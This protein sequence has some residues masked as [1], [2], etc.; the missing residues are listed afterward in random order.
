[1]RVPAHAIR[2]TV[3][4]LL[5]NDGTMKYPEILLLPV[6][7]FL[8]YF[9]T[10]ASAV[11]C[12]KGHARHFKVIHLELNPLWQKSVASKKWFN[13]K[14]ILLTVIFSSAMIF[15]VEFA[16]APPP[17]LEAAVGFVL[18]YFAMVVGRHVSN[19][20]IFGYMI[21]NPG[22]ISGEVAMSH[23]MMLWLSLYQFLVAVIP[24]ALIA[25]VTKNP[26]AVG[27]CAG[28]L[29]VLAHHRAWIRKYERESA[30]EKNK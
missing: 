1:V 24:L 30:V 28:G 8:D 19:L 23:G 29:M 26:F 9:L 4:N 3:V 12:E 20:L 14:H 13:P 22:Q 11:Q 6:F 17:F 15:L 2:V 5:E 21:R 7:M 27:G 25:V 18:V 10:L 16:V